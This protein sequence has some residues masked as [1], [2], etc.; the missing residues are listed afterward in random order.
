MY[1]LDAVIKTVIPARKCLS[2]H[3][4]HPVTEVAQSNQKKE[5]C[6]IILYFTLCLYLHTLKYD[7]QVRIKK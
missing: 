5:G 6:H 2:L 3:M 4:R 1:K 7:L